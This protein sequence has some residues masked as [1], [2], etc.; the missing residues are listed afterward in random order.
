MTFSRILFAMLCALV[1]ASLWAADAK[2][3]ELP[4]GLEVP[5][6]ARPGP[7]FDADRA[8]EAY[9]GLLTAEQKAQSDAYFEG[10]YWLRLWGWLY[11][12]GSCLLYT[13]PSP[14]DS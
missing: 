13:S 12:L 5:A 3:R 10:G 8:T 2:E 11:G 7:D 14:R 4:P 9:L 6:A 1:S